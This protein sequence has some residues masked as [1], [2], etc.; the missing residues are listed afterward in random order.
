MARWKRRLH[1]I[2]SGC[3]VRT[4]D[5]FGSELKGKTC[6][7]EALRLR[8]HGAARDMRIIGTS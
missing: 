4:V 6:R 3:S 1:H 2:G 8:G 7:K 5:P